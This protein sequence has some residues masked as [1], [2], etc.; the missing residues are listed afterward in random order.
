MNSY[1]NSVSDAASMSNV[2]TSR[3][4]RSQIYAALKE[5]ER[6]AK[7][8]LKPKP[9][10]PPRIPM[11]AQVIHPVYEEEKVFRHD[12]HSYDETLTT[13]DST[14]NSSLE[15]K[16]NDVTISSKNS[17]A[18][19]ISS[20]ISPGNRARVLAEIMK[21]KEDAKK[22]EMQK[23]ESSMTK[24]KAPVVEIEKENED[25][26]SFLPNRKDF[27]H[28]IRRNFLQKKDEEIPDVV[29][30]V[31]LEL[32]E[33]YI[34]NVNHKQRKAYISEKQRSNKTDR[35][36]LQDTQAFLQRSA[37]AISKL[38]DGIM[39][40]ENKARFMRAVENT[41][42]GTG[43]EEEI[44]PKH[45]YPERVMQQMHS[46]PLMRNLKTS[47]KKAYDFGLAASSSTCS[48]DYTSRDSGSSSYD[49]YS[50]YSSRSSYDSW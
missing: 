25:T 45:T 22:R 29:A 16:E 41:I 8:A 21:K 35:G 44:V 47:N 28:E 14:K 30:Q 15:S 32:K 43:R 42:F 34:P 38:E 1:A 11:K 10:T 2:S 6:R 24:N 7:K 26:I 4:S 12:L 19:S 31:S 48:S 36:M 40:E 20:K 37:Q 18:K 46:R 39:S 5:R 49:S 3:S 27:L 50:T 33:I 9:V 23:I 13:H 17:E